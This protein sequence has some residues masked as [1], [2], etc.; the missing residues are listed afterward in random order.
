MGKLLYKSKVPVAYIMWLIVLTA[1]VTYIFIISIFLQAII[2][3]AVYF[4][5]SYL[6]FCRNAGTI[7]I[8]ENRIEVKYYFPML[9]TKKIELK[10]GTRVEYI[11]SYY[12]LLSSNRRSVA[13]PRQIFEPHETI[14]FFS[15][16]DK[17]LY[18]TLD[19][20]TSYRSFMVL[21]KYLAERVIS[22]SNNAK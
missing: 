19:L 8:Y 2:F 6:I 5:F 16:E 13:G 3:A 9:Y 10:E 14:K 21:R 11:L 7:L 22:Y 12:Y 20:F 1:G 18:D 4:I 17:E 15:G